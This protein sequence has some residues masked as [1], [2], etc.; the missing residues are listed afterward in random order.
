VPNI[1]DNRRIQSEGS[2]IHL[3]IETF[4]KPIMK[5]ACLKGVLN[6]LFDY[7]ILNREKI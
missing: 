4:N 7:L 6:A 2:W 1:F 3:I 5:N